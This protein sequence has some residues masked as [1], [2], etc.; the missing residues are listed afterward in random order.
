[1][2]FNFC[3]GGSVLKRHTGMHLKLILKK[4]LA[5]RKFFKRYLFIVLIR[6][7]LCNPIWPVQIFR[8]NLPLQRKDVV[9]SLRFFTLC[10]VKFTY[11]NNMYWSNSSYV[12]LFFF[13]NQQN[14]V[15]CY[16]I[17]CFSLC[18]L[19]LLLCRTLLVEWSLCYLFMFSLTVTLE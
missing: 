8:R 10:L 4:I 15:H 6:L 5:F 1:M 19:F 11:G 16:F 18:W 17:D 13:Y 12:C 9:Q 2:I 14:E 3:D 7:H